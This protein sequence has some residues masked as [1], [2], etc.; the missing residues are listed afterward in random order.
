MSSVIGFYELR[1]H[2]GTHIPQP[3]ATQ[4]AAAIAAL[5]APD[6][7]YLLVQPQPDTGWYVEVT[8]PDPASADVFDGAYEIHF[9]DSQATPSQWRAHGNDPE[10]IA[11]GILTWAQSM[12][13]SRS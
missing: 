5:A 3:S 2:D 6:N 9:Q 1:A 4:L 8:L 11:T 10:A 7:T 13:K 12:I